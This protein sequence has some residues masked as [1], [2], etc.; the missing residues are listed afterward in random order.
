MGKERSGKTQLEAG[1]DGAAED[2][3]EHVGAA[4]AA[5]RDAVANEVHGGAHVVGN[6]AHVGHIKVGFCAICVIGKK[7]KDA[8]GENCECVCFVIG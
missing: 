5:G 7:R 2:A 3:A 8:I 6:D 4:G 1:V